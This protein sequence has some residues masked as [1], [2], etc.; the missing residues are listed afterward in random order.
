MM[1]NQHQMNKRKNSLAQKIIGLLIILVM[2]GMLEIGFGFVLLDRYR[3]EIRNMENTVLNSY[4]TRTNQTFSMIN[5]NVRSILFESTE[6]ENITDSCIASTSAQKDSLD[7][8]L[9]Q[10]DSILALKS[11]FLALTKN[12][13]NKFNFFF[14]D[15]KNGKLTEY[16]GCEIYE[17]QPFI[18]LL[19][20]QIEN[21]TLEYTKEGKW[22][23]IDQF[24]CT[25]YS[26]PKGIT[27]AWIEASDFASN[28]LSLSPTHCSSLSIY[29]LDNGTDIT[30]HRNENGTLSQDQ[31][32][33][34][35]NH[36]NFYNLTNARF[37]LLFK[38]D[39]REYENTLFYPMLFLLTIV[40]YLFLVI[41]AVVY[42]RK[43]ILH[44][45]NF[46]YDSLMEF[47]NTAAFNEKS[48]L[49]E[50]AE[51]GKVL[52][53]LADEIQK[54]KIDIYEKQLEKQ[55]VELDYAQMQIR[56]HFYINCL[57]VIQSMAQVGMTEQIQEITFQVS[58]YLR[59]ILKKS[60]EPVTVEKELDF[61]RNY[62]RVLECMNDNI[63]PCDIRCDHKLGQFEIP[64]L[65]IQTFVENSIKH[66]MMP[67]GGWTIQI[68]VAPLDVGEEDFVEIIIKD[69]GPG[70]DGAAIKRFNSGVFENPSS[71][72]HIGIQNA[73]ARLKMLYGDRARVIF[74]NDPSHG[75]CVQI[76][77]PYRQEETQ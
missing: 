31:W 4:I 15:T 77:I 7:A 73:I 36:E 43:N 74:S 53:K 58:G 67:D 28:I 42:V 22:F 57:N 51:T 54:L 69:S 64:P 5:S 76:I 18:D 63:Y 10:N 9:L 29:N 44:Q 26:G 70:F 2:A 20:S 39:A 12:Y 61:T 40:I 16:G 56:P 11:T 62:L 41:M 23:F 33:A 1:K 47:K 34:S 32:G 71:G 60:M 25:I 8:I 48:G 38:I 27:G 30:F 65:L 3:T 35:Q 59:Y 72:N 13:G 17:R 19:L 45:V 68:V 49:I 50:F 21:H 75:A 52:N 46:F 37:S 24:I 6:I 55:K 66:A 14:Y